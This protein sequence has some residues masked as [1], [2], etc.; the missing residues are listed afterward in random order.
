MT[1]LIGALRVSL[2]AD[3]TAF[4][5]G[6]KRSQRQAQTTATGIQKAL[7]GISGAVKAG[8]AG[9]VAGLSVTAII[10]AGRAALEYAGHLGEL[11]ET[12]GVTSKDLQVFSYAAGQV[13]VSQETLQNS[14]QKLTITLGQMKA[15]AEAPRKALEALHKG[16]ADQVAVAPDTGAAFKLI[17]GAMQNV[18]DR[19]QRAAVEV[20]L[21]KKA[22]AGVDNLLSGAEGN[23]N[24][25]AQAAEKLGIVLSD[26][27][28]KNAD[29][30]ADKLEALETV[31]KAR[32]AGAV[33]DNA[34]SILS[35]ASALATLI[36]SIGDAIRGWKRLQAEFSVPLHLDQNPLH[37]MGMAGRAVDF[38]E[39][40][41]ALTTPAG[42]KPLVGGDN[43]GKFLAPAAAHHAEDHSAEDALRNKNEFDQQLRK[44]QLDVLQATQDLATDYVQRT[45]IGIQILDAEKAGFDAEQRYQ[46]ALFDLTKGKQGQSAEQSRQ[47][48]LEY[49]K[50]DALKRQALL[51]EE[52]V[53]RRK[54]VAMLVE[55][56]FD[57]QRQKLQ[58]EQQL[59]TT[60][61]EQRDI[62]LRLLELTYRQER[63]KLEAVLAD[64]KA[65]DAAK[66]DARRRLEG[67]NR[68]YGTDRQN[69]INQTRGPLDQWA[70]SVPQTAAQINEAFQS[71][72]SQGLEG[73]SSAIT[74]VITGTKSLKDAFGELASSIISDLIRM[75]VRMLIFRALSSVLGGGLGQSLF[76]VSNGVDPLAPLP[77]TSGAWPSFA[78]G[79]SFTVMGRRGTDRNLLSLNGLPI[80]NVNYGE[81]ISVANDTGGGGIV[82]NQTIAPNFAGNAATH[83]DLVK[84]AVLTKSATLQAINERQRRS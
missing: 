77:V 8:L 7:G 15:G 52:Q 24:D 84:M 32:I 81:R 45:T 70:A 65:S 62:Q 31:L 1:A 9:F 26:E 76:P 14:L 42:A 47:L 29:R 50:T 18:G 36:G 22:G 11:A 80:A 54:D 74:D 20:A 40:L 43:V 19:S 17:A 13:G 28:I 79:G 38:R 61:K 44:A 51:D 27:Q 10:Q 16:L 63:A 71:I 4:E 69:V 57:I 23:L 41:F 2:S 82:V 73:L 6:M 34:S 30:T 72:E 75:S 12:L 21:F 67:L 49:D 25:F 3:T 83:D 78:S 39:R 48:T 64:E 5:A 68:T 46:V 35:L 37:T 66:E 60:A 55:T 59:A 58:S 53:E 33:A 56:D